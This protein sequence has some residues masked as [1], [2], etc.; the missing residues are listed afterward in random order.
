MKKVFCFLFTLSFFFIFSLN[1]FAHP[2]NTDAQG[3]HTDRSTGEYHYHHG[4]PAHQHEDLDGD[5]E[6]D[7]PYD[8]V[9]KTGQ[10]SG[11]SSSGI[12]DPPTYSA[13][14]DSSESVPSDNS[15]SAPASSKA[16]PFFQKLVKKHLFTVIAFFFIFIVLP[17]L[18]IWNKV[19]ERRKAKAE[20]IRKQREHEQWLA[21][22]AKYTEL[23]GGKTLLA[24]S[25]TPPDCNVGHDGLPAANH[26]SEKWGDDYTFYA[27]GNS[28]VF[29]RRE[30]Y[31]AKYLSP[32]NACKI[33]RRR[34]CSVCH[35]V[36]PDLSWYGRYL[37]IKEI[38]EKYQIDQ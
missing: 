17:A 2:G 25:G 13:S 10:S 8:Y 21:D 9:D 16:S 6:P 35:P 28:P 31:H 30:C 19:E 12:P 24:L 5:G 32:T 1:A 11:T 26:G 36:L 7:C 15:Y 14:Y 34:P 18:H 3:G 22:K 29:H 33:K 37:R 23:Y 27:S 38:K 4:Y 20:V